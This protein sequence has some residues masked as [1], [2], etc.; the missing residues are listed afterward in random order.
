MPRRAFPTGP[1]QTVWLLSLKGSGRVPAKR[2]PQGFRNF[3]IKTRAAHGN[4][5]ETFD[6]YCRVDD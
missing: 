5:I 2:Q 6:K 3:Y 4:G 1:S